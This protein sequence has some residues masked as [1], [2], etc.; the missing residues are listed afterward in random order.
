MFYPRRAGPFK[1][2]PARTYARVKHRSCHVITEGSRDNAVSLNNRP[3][4]FGVA[5]PPL[6]KEHIKVCRKPVPL[7]CDSTLYLM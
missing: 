4:A 3:R 5:F 1:G 2:R 6:Q 7:R